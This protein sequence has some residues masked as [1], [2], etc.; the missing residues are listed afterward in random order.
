ML[1]TF[2][3]QNQYYKQT[4]KELSR[5]KGIP[6]SLFWKRKERPLLVSVR[7]QALNLTSSSKG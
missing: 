5:D 7:F 1:A 3:P 2:L 4:Q 6:Q